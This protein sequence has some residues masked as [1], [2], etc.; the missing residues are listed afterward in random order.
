MAKGSFGRP[1]FDG[2]SDLTAREPAPRPDKIGP[3]SETR[4]PSIFLPGFRCVSAGV[5]NTSPQ[6]GNVIPVRSPTTSPSRSCRR[7]RAPLLSWFIGR[8]RRL[9]QAALS[10]SLSLFVVPPMIPPFSF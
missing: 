2:D 8:H 3:P 5:E 9:L 6:P 4:R 7:H 1:G 10:L